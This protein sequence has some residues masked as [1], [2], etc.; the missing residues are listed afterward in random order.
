[1]PITRMESNPDSEQ[2]RVLHLFVGCQVFHRWSPV[3]AALQ[4]LTI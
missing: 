2:K 4:E 1:M 3:F